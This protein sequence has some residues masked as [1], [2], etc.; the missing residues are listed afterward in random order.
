[1]VEEYP[2]VLSVFYMDIIYDIIAGI[3]TCVCSR[4]VVSVSYSSIVQGRFLRD[5]KVS[6][7]LIIAERAP[8]HA[9]ASLLLVLSPPPLSL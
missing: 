3:Y 8:T 5:I 1:M 4:Y 2:P 7:D 9:S 6:S